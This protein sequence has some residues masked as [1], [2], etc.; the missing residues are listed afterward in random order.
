MG[1][2]VNLIKRRSFPLA[3]LHMKRQN[4]M[5]L[6]DHDYLELVVIL[7]GSGRHLTHSGSYTLKRGDVFVVPIG[8]EHGYG[9]GDLELVNVVFDPAGLP[10]PHGQL[11]RLPGY[12]ALV[13]LEP[14][15][16]EQHA[17]TSHLHLCDEE[18]ARVSQL[19]NELGDELKQRH[20]GFEAAATG[21]LTSLLV[22][23]ARTY[24]DVT[25]PRALALMQLADLVGWIADHLG[26]AITVDSLA[27]RVGMSRSTLLRA[28]KR[29]LDCSPMDY[30]IRCRIEH[31]QQLLMTS[32]ERIA[33][34]ARAA[35]YEDP[36]YFGRL[37]HKQTDMTPSAWRKRHRS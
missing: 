4:A 10:L 33:T 29:G 12:H 1:R 14:R 30:V 11:E 18:L 34:V 6:H 13:T 17:F 32:N 7:G 27:Q 19:L 16:R 22:T 31:A 23:L 3:T 24:R 20:N 26:E 28:F 36:D 25:A 35:G 9:E 37:F 8:M 5:E 21:M 15:M 2:S